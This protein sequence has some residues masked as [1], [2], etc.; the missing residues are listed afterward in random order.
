MS[1][2]EYNVRRST[3]DRILESQA[4]LMRTTRIMPVDQG[5][6]VIGVQLFGV[7]GNSLL[8]RLGMQNGDVL[9]RINGLEI[10]SPDRALEAYSRLRT[11]DHLQISLT[12]NGQPVNVDFNI[13]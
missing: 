3:V 10:A 6:R 9:N 4:E 1:A 8:G 12:R 7:R 11:S 13:R 2:N 5:G